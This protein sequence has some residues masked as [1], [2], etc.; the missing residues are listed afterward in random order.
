MSNNRR[1]HRFSTWPV[2]AL[3]VTVGVSVAAISLAK[4]ALV[5]AAV[6]KGWRNR[7]DLGLAS[8]LPRRTAWV[9]FAMLCAL[10]LSTSYTVATL[11]EALRDCVK[12]TK[13]LLIVLIPILLVTRRQVWTAMACYGVM[14]VFVLLSSCALALGLALPWVVDPVLV[15]SNSVFHEYLQQSIMTAAFI[16]LCWHLRDELRL[17]WQRRVAIGLSLLST[18]NVLL[19]LKGRTGYVIV[20]VVVTSILLW[21]LPQRRRW[22][23]LALA[24]LLLALTY[25]ASP[26]VQS[27]AQLAVSEARSYQIGNLTPSSTGA[28]LNFWYRS[29]QAI[30]ERPLLGYGA[31]SWPSQYQRLDAG[32]DPWYKG[33]GGNPHQEYLLWGVLLGLGGIALQW[34]LLVALWR[35]SAD[36][37]LRT[38][39]AIR[40][41]ILV[42]ATAN[43]FNCALYDSEIGD[44][45]CF[46]LGLLM[47]MGRTLKPEHPPSQLAPAAAVLPT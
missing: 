45:F 2:Y 14:Q 17:Q 10:A 1:Q 23:V 15:R 28:R 5:L 38:Q 20:M 21:E 3:S 34:L 40:T 41:I 33:S 39:R 25:L 9:I 12:Y 42:L 19:M 47:A 46:M 30:S 6:F 16:G 32:Q 7:A 26:Q 24:P 13:L 36:F 44:Y 22:M 29:V 11:P 4:L 8:R 27:R 43:L 31:G 37:P 18:V 35:D